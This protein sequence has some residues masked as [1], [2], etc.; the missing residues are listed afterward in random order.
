[1]PLLDY[2]NIRQGTA[3]GF[4]PLCPGR[5]E[6]IR[7]APLIKAATIRGKA[8]PHAQSGAHFSQKDLT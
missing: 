6:Y 5:A 3:L 7:T 2:V 8:V 1:M 4:Y